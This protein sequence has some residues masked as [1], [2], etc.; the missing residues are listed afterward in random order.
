MVRYPLLFPQVYAHLGVEPPKGILLHG[1]PGCGKSLLANAIAGELDIPYFKVSAPELVTGTSGDSEARIR[2]LFEAAVAAAPSLV[3]IDEIDAIT[4]KRD[5][6]QRGMDKRIV[7]QLLSC[8]DSLGS[9]KPVIILGATNRAD[10]LDTG[11]RR[12]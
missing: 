12:A 6:S 11:L 10:S 9:E 7:A 4:P 8:M 5:G 3:F 2:S 1:P